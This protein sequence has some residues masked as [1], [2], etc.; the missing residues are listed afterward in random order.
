MRNSAW[1]VFWALK[2]HV[3]RKREILK[4]KKDSEVR[5]LIVTI[6]FLMNMDDNKREWLFSGAFIGGDIAEFFI[7]NGIK[8]LKRLTKTIK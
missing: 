7:S 2:L 1:L 3:G 5:K 4:D 6:K 8:F